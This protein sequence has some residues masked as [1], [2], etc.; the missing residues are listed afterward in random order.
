[1]L[2]TARHVINMKVNSEIVH[3]PFSRTKSPRP[4][5]FYTHRASQFRAV[6]SPTLGGHTWGVAALLDGAGAG[7]AGRREGVSSKWHR[8]SLSAA[9]SLCGFARASGHAPGHS[10]Q[11]GGCVGFLA[12]PQ[13]ARDSWLP[14]TAVCRLTFRRSDVRVD[15][16]G[17]SVQ[18]LVGCPPGVG[19]AAFPA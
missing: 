15:S 7:Q 19:Q 14:A 16:A 4:G 2:V 9:S 10:R 13:A 5:G 1:M 18:G 12:G 8:G 11:H 17:S 3:V 6:T